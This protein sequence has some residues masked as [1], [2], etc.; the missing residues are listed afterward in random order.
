MI[1]RASQHEPSCWA[2]VPAAGIGSRMHAACPKQY[3]QIDG[4]TILQLTL[5]RLHHLPEIRGIV[6]ATRAEDE[7][8]D[9]TMLEGLTRVSRVDGGSER[10]HSVLLGLR[11]LSEH[12]HDEDW[13]LVHDVVRPCVTAGDIR[14][15]LEELADDAVGGILATQLADTVKQVGED[16]RIECTLD[17]RV[18]WAAATPQVFR[19]GLLCR[20]LDAAVAAGQMVTDECEAMELAGHKPLVVQ[21]RSDNIKITVPQDLALA[22]SILGEQ[23]REG[24]QQS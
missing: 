18:L 4:K 17:R 8:L 19:Y 20:A 11:A 5:E 12:A 9:Q 13:V 2:V 23:L 1:N 22:R 21:G 24:E 3:L 10:M 6:L 15:L 7:Y 14:S 16:R